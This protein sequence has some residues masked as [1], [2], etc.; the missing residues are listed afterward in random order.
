MHKKAFSKFQ[1][2]LYPLS[3]CYHFH[4]F[5]AL[6]TLLTLFVTPTRKF[7]SSS[8]NIGYD[9][10]RPPSQR[11]RE[12]AW[13]VKVKS[14]YHKAIWWSKNLW[15]AG[16]NMWSETEWGL[17]SSP[18]TWR[19]IE[20]KAQPVY[21]INCTLGSCTCLGHFPYL[22]MGLFLSRH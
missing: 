16:N 6:A 8:Q 12:R 7:P 10:W 13:A 2:N 18:F 21:P 19:E 11:E 1:T 9:L 14:M 3:N 4:F 20:Y 5:F 17:I 15:I 22:I